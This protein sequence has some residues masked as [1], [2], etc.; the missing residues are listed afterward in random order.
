[1]RTFGMFLVVAGLIWAVIAFNMS[2]TI[3]TDSETIGSGE[4]SV[5]VPSQ[6]VHN[7]GLMEERRNHLILSGLTVLA[8]VI[9]IGFGSMTRQGE[10]NDAN[11]KPCPLC[12]E[13]IQPAAVKC[14]FCG[15]DLPDSFR[16]QPQSNPTSSDDRLRKLIAMIEHGNTSYETYAEAIGKVGG[17]IKPKGFLVDMHYVVTLDGMQNRVDKFEDLRQWFL[18][19]V[20]PRA[21]A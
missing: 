10:S 1:M 16:I 19:H 13:L 8:G 17:N 2:T 11:L 6:T 9:L 4:Y 5:Y 3:T 20:A 18:D 7:I 15:A 12:A 14:R 21:S